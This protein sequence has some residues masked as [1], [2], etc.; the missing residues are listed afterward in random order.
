M[1]IHGPGDGHEGDHGGLGPAGRCRCHFCAGP[2]GTGYH[3]PLRHRA[4]LPRWA[5]GGD[6]SI[7][8][9]SRCETTVSFGSLPLHIYRSA[10]HTPR[11]VSAMTRTTIDANNSVYWL[12]DCRGSQGVCVGHRHRGGVSQRPRLGG[13]PHSPR[14][15]AR[16]H[17]CRP[18]HSC[19]SS[20]SRSYVVDVFTSAAPSAVDSILNTPIGSMVDE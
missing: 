9:W 2:Q 4:R 10:V 17:L 20:L 7:L 11:T 15:Q 5:L 14:L 3:T 13:R 1:A 16:G 18:A 6:N 8:H 19:P 12:C